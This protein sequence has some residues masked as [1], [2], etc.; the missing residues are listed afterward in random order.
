MFRLIRV[1]NGRNNVGEPMYLPTSTVG[2]WYQLGETLILKNGVLSTCPNAVRPQFIC[3]ENYDTAINAPKRIAVYPVDPACEYACEA[4]ETPATLVVGN[5]Y[6]HNGISGI[7][8]TTEG[9]TA[10]LID[11]NNAKEIGD[12]VIVRFP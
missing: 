10:Q 4:T 12:T 7:T 8:A 6:T 3:G 5:L 1:R 2:K 11:K 9:G